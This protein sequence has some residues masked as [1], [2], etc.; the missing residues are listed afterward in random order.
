MAFIA[1]DEVVR[2]AVR[3]A[4]L[5]DL[6][7]SKQTERVQRHSY[8]GIIQERFNDLA[9]KTNLCLIGRLDH[10]DASATPLCSRDAAK[11][12]SQYTDGRRV[13]TEKYNK[14]S[15]SGQKDPS[16]FPQ[17][18]ERVNDRFSIDYQRAYIIFSA[19]M[20]GTPYARMELIDFFTKEIISDGDDVAL[21][22]EGIE[23]SDDDTAPRKRKMSD[24]EDKGN[25]KKCRKT[26]DISDEIQKFKKTMDTM[27]ELNRV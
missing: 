22:E 8:W 4:A 14:W 6:H 23:D 19:L 24:K 27:S 16:R 9:V 26:N 3:S 13:S 1:D 21:H 10:I 20:C 7:K 11:L 5:D 17:F 18:L 25:R 2:C 15:R 12:K